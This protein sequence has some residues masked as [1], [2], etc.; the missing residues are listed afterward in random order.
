MMD[1]K[2]LAERL[3]YL[4]CDRLLIINCDD[5]GVSHAANVATSKAMVEG[6]ATSATLMVPCSSFSNPITNRTMMDRKSLAERLGYLACDRL[7]IINCDDLGVS[8]AANVATSKAMVEGVATSA[9]LMVPCSS[10]REAAG[11]FAGWILACT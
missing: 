5:L 6:V 7:L 1:Q 2:S 9:T 3:G 10:A 11:M 8:H 4:A